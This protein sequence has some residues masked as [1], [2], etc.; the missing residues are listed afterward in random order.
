MICLSEIILALSWYASIVDGFIM[1][2]ACWS[3]IGSG[4]W[5]VWGVGLVCP[6][7]EC[8]NILKEFDYITVCFDNFSILAIG[9]GLLVIWWAIT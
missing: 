5:F 6:H 3:L 7:L 1:E 4:S 8:D 2:M 9:A